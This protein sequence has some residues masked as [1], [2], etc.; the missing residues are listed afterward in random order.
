MSY[1]KQIE[2]S[3]ESFPEM[4]ALSSELVHQLQDPEV[5]FAQLEEQ[6]QYDPGMTSN[7]LR[8]ANS[9][10]FGAQGNVTSLRTALMRLGLRRIWE[11]IIASTVSPMMVQTLEG[12]ELRPRDLLRHSAWVAVASEEMARLVGFQDVKLLFTAGLLHDM[13]KIITDPF[14][15]GEKSRLLHLSGDSFEQR[16]TLL[17]GLNHARTGFRLMEKWNIPQEITSAVLWHHEPQSAQS[18]PL[19]ANTVHLADIL[20]YSQGVGTGIDGMKYAVSSRAKATLG[21]KGQDMEYVSSLTLDK[22]N[23]LQSLLT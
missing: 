11:L 12:Y 21:L 6:L 5:D 2:R 13:G 16:E 15:R 9:A 18:F 8:L 19:I 20:A 17:L 3:L 7:I 22:M 1:K 10:Y 14:V 4:P 23:E